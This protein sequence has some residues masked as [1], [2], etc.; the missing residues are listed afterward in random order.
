MTF[1]YPH[2]WYSP[3]TE[4]STATAEAPPTTTDERRFNQAD[5]DAIVKDRLERQKRSVDA[6]S[7]AQQEAAEAE[8]LKAAQEWQKVAE[9]KEAAL[10][11]ARA[12][13]AAERLS[14]ARDRVAAK[15]HLPE[16]LAKRL[17]GTTEDELDAD[18]KDIA[19]VIAPATPA[20]AAA[21]TP[22]PETGPSKA[23]GYGPRAGVAAP[24]TGEDPAMVVGQR[25]QPG[26]PAGPAAAPLNG[27]PVGVERER[28]IA[29][30]KYS[31]LA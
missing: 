20:A 3:N 27:N 29:T 15:Y 30:K 28:L 5:I 22:T 6:A 24:A 19:S 25:A 7:K 14:M 12:E 1:P 9:Q 11:A 16:A 23:R 10:V 2:V 18:A 8:R 31:G 26:N 17:V 13:L 21:T 4:G